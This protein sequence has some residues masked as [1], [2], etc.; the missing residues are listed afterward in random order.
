MYIRMHTRHA[1]IFAICLALLMG[2][3]HAGAQ[4]SQG[5]FQY[6]DLPFSARLN[7]LGG[8]NVS[9]SDGELSL[10][11]SNPALLTKDSHELLQ[12]SYSFFG[13]AMHFGSVIFGYNYKE[14]YFAAGIHYLDFGR[15]DYADEYGT[16]LG[17]Q[18]R[19]K[20]FMVTLMYTRQLAEMWRVGV[21][22]KPMFSVY[23]SYKS[24][25]LGADIGAHFELP[26]RS[27][28]IGL[29]LQNVGWQLK[30]FY[31]DE[32]GQKRE[33][34]PLNLALGINYKLPHAPI[35]F[36]LTADKMQ[37]WNLG[38]AAN[39]AENIKW[40]D[41]LFRH[42]IWAIDIVPKSE[43]FY[44]T[45]SYNHRRRM[46]MTLKD[47]RSLAGFGLGAGLNI[48]PVRVAIAMSQFTKSN[49]T[50]QVSFTLDIN[51]LMK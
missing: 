41:M 47:S 23:E 50:F 46:E 35:R 13:P 3:G 25:A 27:L 40:Y 39:V 8:H 6:L 26:D 19:A 11:T 22:L 49:Y 31:S 21:A 12:L 24:M 45:L 9:Y 5:T 44:F 4:S 51:S 48:K 30:G 29:T 43:K 16:L 20:D 10:A 42:T 17:T 7:M 14:N 36:S 1:H 18:F 2:L 37:R 34:L 33:M 28:Q 38:Y 15:F 32:N